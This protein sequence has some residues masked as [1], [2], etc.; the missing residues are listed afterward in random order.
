MLK[1]VKRKIRLHKI[2]KE[3]L[4]PRKPSATMDDVQRKLQQYKTA[5]PQRSG[6]AYGIDVSYIS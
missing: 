6:V 1:S 5:E 3:A 2:K 4:Q